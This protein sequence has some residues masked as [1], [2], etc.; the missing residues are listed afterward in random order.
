MEED[1]KATCNECGFSGHPNE[2]D[3]ALSPYHDLRCPNCE[4]T[5]VDWTCGSYVNNTLVIR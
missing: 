2:F 4:T 5:D 1:I 3:A